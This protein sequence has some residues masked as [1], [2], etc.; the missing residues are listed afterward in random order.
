M[1][2]A[3]EKDLNAIVSRETLGRL[4][5]LEALVKKWNPVI[6]L[7]S[8]GTIPHIQQ[9]HILDSIQ[10]FRLSGPNQGVWCDLGSGGGFPGLVVALLAQEDGDRFHVQ[11]VESDGRK[12]TFLRE[13]ARQLGLNVTVFN[14]R[15]EDLPAIS[16][17]VL[18]ARALT[19]LPNLCKFA[20][21]HL[22]SSGVALFP[23]GA[24][25][26]DEVISA[27]QHWRFDLTV[28]PSKTDSAAAVLEMRN[29]RH[30]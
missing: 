4:L 17:S 27:R 30:A 28:H 25:Y 23:K 22:D 10:I 16:A 15:I 11:L 13:A 9:R 21:L 3:T 12:C 26:H 19:S 5:L 18:S 1:S 7:V 14:S 20:S 2:G 29:I 6:N 8:A 24:R